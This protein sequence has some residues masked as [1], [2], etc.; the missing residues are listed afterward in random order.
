[1]LMRGLGPYST[2]RIGECA[3]WWAWKAR[4]GSQAE[5]RQYLRKFSSS[6][7]PSLLLVHNGNL[8]IRKLKAAPRTELGLENRTGNESEREKKAGLE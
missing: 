8:P 5:R 4:R 3:G 1:M 7:L 6:S 2:K